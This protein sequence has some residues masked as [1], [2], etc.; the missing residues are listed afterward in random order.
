RPA[1]ENR[2][3]DVLVRAAVAPAAVD[4]A[5]TYPSDCAAAVAAVAVHRT[6]E[7][8]TGIR[9]GLGRTGRIERVG[10]GKD[11]AGGDAVFILDSRSAGL[12]TT[13]APRLAGGCD[14]DCARDH[15][16]DMSGSWHGI[17]P[18][19]PE[20]PDDAALTRMPSDVL[21]GVGRWTHI[22][23]IIRADVAR[24]EEPV[25][26]DTRIN[27]DV[28][29][30]VRTAIGDRIPH[31]TGADLELG[32]NLAGL[33]V[34]RLEPAIEGSVERD[35]TGGDE[36]PAPVREVLLVFPHL[37]ARGRIP[38]HECTEVAARARVVGRAR[39]DER[40]AAEVLGRHGSVVH[41]HV[42]GGRVEPPR[43]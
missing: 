22:R 41:A 11:T 35:V 39:P 5:G 27:R 3:E 32:E 34:H 12:A 19:E 33:G 23:R 31:D 36:R 21:V 14:K 40:R 24:E 20:D 9:V 7:V 13:L 15:R 1:I 16:E 2:G 18:S 42:V 29:F 30:A 10:D 43:P 4:Q 17:L 26:A 38:R 25:A 28:L 6:E 37:L 8:A